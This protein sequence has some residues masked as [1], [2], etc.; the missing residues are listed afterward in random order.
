MMAAMARISE[1]S[2]A[3]D[4]S[5]LDILNLVSRKTE[6]GSSNKEKSSAKMSG[7][8]SVLPIIAI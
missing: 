5:A 2:A 4:E 8:K 1:I 6:N 3:K 7:A